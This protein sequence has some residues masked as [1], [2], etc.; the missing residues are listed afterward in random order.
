MNEA[1]W[2]DA[3]LIKTLEGGGVAVM[4]TDT[5]YGI[6]GQAL[7]K[8]TFE[9]LYAVRKRPPQKPSIVLIGDMSELE[10]FGV[11]LSLAQKEKLAEYWPGPVSV[12]LECPNND[13]DYLH[14]GTNSLAFRMP[15]YQNFRKFLLATGP[16]V[17]PSANLEGMPPAK[18]IVEAKKYFGDSIDMYIDGG[19]ISGSPSRLIKLHSD[20]T[21]SILR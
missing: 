9:R 21:P 18:N 10:K 11:E 16:L 6:V 2:T 1:I 14:C 12:V 3:H 5:L 19:E 13:L 4:P 8:E 20:G 17:A 7:N 15:A